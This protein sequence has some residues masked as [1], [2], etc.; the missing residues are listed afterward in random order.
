MGSQGFVYL[1]SKGAVK[2]TQERNRLQLHSNRMRSLL[3]A[4]AITDRHIYVMS[5]RLLHG[6]KEVQRNQNCDYVDNHGKYF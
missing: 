1:N 2:V 4:Q 3:Y 5:P 6:P